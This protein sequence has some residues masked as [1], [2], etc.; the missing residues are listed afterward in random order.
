MR[1]SM[2]QPG[3]FEETLS[4]KLA[5]HNTV[6]AEMGFLNLFFL[7]DYSFLFVT[8]KQWFLNS[9][10]GFNRPDWTD[11]HHWQCGWV[12]PS[13]WAPEHDGTVVAQQR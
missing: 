2:T 3:H 7:S 6:N 13:I 10:C 12:W 4:R 8:L 11:L 5:N 1:S 9:V